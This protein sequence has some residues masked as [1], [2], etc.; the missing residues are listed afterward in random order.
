M[1]IAYLDPGN[2]ESDLQS[3]GIAGYGVRAF[4]M[5]VNIFHYIHFYVFSSFYGCYYWLTCWDCC[6]RGFP[7]A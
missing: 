4:L 6:Y 7:L 5:K 1:S 2:I 3:G